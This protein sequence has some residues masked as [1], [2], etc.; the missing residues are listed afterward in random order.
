[1]SLPMEKATYRA[2]ASSSAGFGMSSKGNSQI[3]IDCEILTEGFQG[4]RIAWV[5]TFSPG[6]T[7]RTLEAL[8]IMGWQGEDLAELDAGCDVA[9]LIPEEFD[10]ACDV[11][12][13][14]E[15]VDRLKANWVNR[16][17]GGR[18]AFKTKLEGGELKAFAAS[19]KD[20]VKNARGGAP[21]AKPAASGGNGQKRPQQ[22]HP[23]APGGGMDDDIPFGSADVAHEP[24]PIS[25]LLR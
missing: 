22:P 18:F 6:A 5:G 2:R 21:R 7:D 8:R 11:E 4:E 3:A 12:A 17:G 15:G 10:L 20:A 24:S 9:K 16:I 25:R 13:D 19:M 1:M 14:L 23:N